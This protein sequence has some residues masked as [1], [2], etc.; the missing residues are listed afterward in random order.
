MSANFV[1]WVTAMA[2]AT[3]AAAIIRA[4][5][6]VRRLGRERPLRAKLGQAMSTEVEARVTRLPLGIVSLA[7]RRLPEPQR[8]ELRK[9]W[10]AELA[11]IAEETKHYP[12]T[13]WVLRVWRS[14][15]FALGL[16]WAGWAIGRDATTPTPMPV[17]A[18]VHGASAA[19]SFVEAL[20]IM[21][22]G[23]VLTENGQILVMLEGRKIEVRHTNGIIGHIERVSD[24][25]D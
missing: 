4:T 2:S 6:H 7:T 10:L 15:C 22:P 11:Q 1:S 16:V 12:I 9:E 21:N 8:S 19:K 17:P 23:D 20:A 18:P 14:M 3:T 13:S 5:L 25:T 24:D